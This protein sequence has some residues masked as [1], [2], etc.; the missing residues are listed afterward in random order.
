MTTVRSNLYP[1]QLM[2]TA[3]P[4][5]FKT[6][7]N[8]HPLRCRVCGKFTYVDEDAFTVISYAVQAGLDDP[9]HCEW[10]SE[11]PHNAA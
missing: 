9:F 11:V 1:K 6:E 2:P 3:G 8:Q 5:V 4:T 7:R 10:C